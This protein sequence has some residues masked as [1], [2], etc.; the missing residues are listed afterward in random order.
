MSNVITTRIDTDTAKRL[1]K[2]VEKSHSDKATF[3]R[4]IIIKGL[5]EAERQDA[6]DSYSSG[7]ISLGKFS[8]ILQIT[9]WDALDLLKE[10]GIKLQYAIEDLE[11]DLEI[12]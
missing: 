9:K 7:E 6:I 10:R 2:A 4:R 3:L 1:K 5:K 8:E 11:E 12:D